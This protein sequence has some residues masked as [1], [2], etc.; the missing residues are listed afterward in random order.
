MNPEVS[1]G[2]RRA[3]LALLAV[4]VLIVVMDLTIINV[5]LTPIQQS[6]DATN[7]ELQWSLDT[8]LITFAAFLFT[9]GVCADRF[10][11]KRTLMAGLV[12]F[13][14]SSVLGAYADTITEL[15]V[16][17]GVMGVGAAVVPTVTLA[18]IMSVFPPAERP[19]AIAV[20]ASAAGVAF[21]VGPV[22]GGL[23]L[24]QFWWGSIFLINAPLVV[25]GL[26][27]MGWLVPE[28]KNPAPARFDPLGVLLSIAAVGL[29]VYGIVTGGEDNEWLAAD[30]LGGLVGGVVLLVLLLV[31]ESRMATPSLDVSLLRSARFSAGS[32]AIALCF[33]ALIGAIFITQFYYQAVLGF[34]PMKAGLLLLPMGIGSVIMSA[35][36]P[37]LVMRF[38]PRAVVAA[39]ASVMAVSFILMSQMTADTPTWLLIVAQLVFGL[40]WGCIM[41]PATASLMSVVPPVK[42]GAGQAV[43]QTMRQVAGALGVAV[44]GSILGVVYRS[45][46]EESVSVLPEAL[47]DEAA[48]SIGGT[49]RAVEAAELGDQ[50]P[51][52][53]DK[54]V[55]TYLSGMEI[56]ML[57]AAGVV[58]LAAAVSLRWLPKTAPKPP[59]PPVPKP[60]AGEAAGAPGARV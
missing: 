33:F 24:E 57:V 23:L 55:D 56:T 11:R 13:G 7:A 16:W 35:R 19:K 17:R 10:G 12:V 50:A 48:G 3:V 41:A 59:V 43:S 9:G 6:L 14:A 32:G 2:R 51:A 29:L 27:L 39:G 54:A 38:G 30:T 1:S 25:V 44:I 40:G 60:A 42:A 4:T 47:R 5:A 8:Y 53:I 22:L 15:I 58:L 28:S 52:L 46:M 34:S 18:I 49:L 20:W 31:I 26:L 37:T 21:A 45:G 36:C